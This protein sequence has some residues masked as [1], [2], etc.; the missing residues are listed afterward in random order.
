MSRLTARLH[1]GYR[2]ED[3]DTGKRLGCN[4]NYHKDVDGHLDHCNL[5]ENER[6]IAY[7]SIIPTFSFFSGFTGPMLVATALRAYYVHLLLMC[8]DWVQRL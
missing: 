6:R 5:R 1:Y 8:R 4:T 7:Y 3:R 2:H